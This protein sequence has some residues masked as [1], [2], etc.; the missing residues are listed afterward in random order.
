M[1]VR[2]F[3][4]EL[5]PELIAQEPLSERDRSRLLVLERFGEGLREH[6]FRDLPDLLSSRDLLVVNDTRV[7]P[8]RLWAR[9]K[10]GRRVELL[11]LGPGP[12]GHWR[13][14]LRP[15]K[16][17]KPGERVVLEDGTEVEVGARVQG[18]EDRI[19][20]FPAGVDPLAL[21][22]KL[23]QPPLPPYIRRP[24]TE[25]D[26]ERYQ[27][28]FA[29]KSGSTAAPTAG[30]HFTEAVTER[31]REKGIRITSVTLHV[32]P[33]TFLPIRAQ[34]VENH[35]MHEEFC[36]V[37]PEIFRAVEETK[38]REGKVVAVGTTVVRALETAA[39]RGTPESG[40][41]GWTDLYIY[42][43]FEFLWVDAL[44]TNF[45]LPRSSLLVLVCAFAGRERVLRAYQEAVRRRFR[46]YSY[47]DAM[48]V[49]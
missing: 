47:G 30:L 35:H 14:L 41:S 7:F 49:Y 26:R 19:I 44:V 36:T 29:K 18:R 8:A 12:E 32:G 13:A 3:D 46:F 27:T 34:R 21:A 25:A 10:T 38:A 11:A 2:E 33:G 45:H 15:S 24:P 6:R 22:E 48:L 20:R 39:R 4:Y 40:F 37:E 17:V 16:A 28:I 1:D 23:G 42:P 43:P 31:L 5:P 9:R